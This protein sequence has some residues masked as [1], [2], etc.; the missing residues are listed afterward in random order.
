MG[1]PD[2][3]ERIRALKAQIKAEAA[4]AA[5]AEAQLKQLKQS[6]KVRPAP[7]HPGLLRG[8]GRKRFRRDE[9]EGEGVEA[10]GARRSEAV[11]A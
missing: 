3:R 8:L 7:A 1:Q 4:G 5:A 2:A 9:Q 10:K 11:W 6:E